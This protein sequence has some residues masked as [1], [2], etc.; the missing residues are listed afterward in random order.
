MTKKPKRL[1]GKPRGG[2]CMASIMTMVELTDRI[3]APLMN[4]IGALNM[5]TEAFADVD[6]AGAGA[7]DSVSLDGIRNSIDAANVGLIELSESAQRM[8]REPIT[9]PVVWDTSKN[10]EVFTNTGMERFQQEI[11]STNYMLQKLGNT[12][13]EITAKASNMEVIPSGMIP[14]LE[15]VSSRMGAIV[16]RVEAMENNTFGFNVEESNAQLES[17]RSQLNQISQL[18]GTMKSAMES[19]NISVANDSFNQIQSILNGMEQSFRDNPI[20]VPIEWDTSSNIEVFTNTGIERFQQEVNSTNAMLDQ[21]GAKQLA[22]ANQASGVDIFPENMVNDLQGISSRMSDINDRIRVIESNPLNLGSDVANRELESLRSQLNQAV[23]QQED[24]NRAVSNM[25]ISAANASYNRL[26]STISSTEQYIRD[27]VDEQGK[28]TTAINGSVS[29]AE[30]LNSTFSNLMQGLGVMTLINKAVNMVTSSVDSAVSRFDTLNNFPKMMQ[31]MGYSAE[32]ANA[33]VNRLSDGIK[34]LPTALND[35]TGYVSQFEVIT[36]NL[37]YATES[38]IALNNAIL[39]GGKSAEVASRA[40]ET[41]LTMFGRGTVDATHWKSL[42]TDMTYALSEVAEAFGYTSIVAGGDFYTAL[43]DGEITMA[44]FNN[45]LIELSNATGGF[46]EVAQTATGGI[47]TAFDN[48]GNAVNRG[49]V[50]ILEAGD[51]LLANTQFESVAGLISRVGDAF[52]SVLNR[53]ATGV[54]VF[55]TL[56]MPIATLATQIADVFA[57]NWSIIAPIVYGIVAALVVYNATMGIGWLTTLRAAAAIVWKTVCDWAETAALIAMTVA[58]DG[59][60]AALAACPITWI[61]IVII[62]LVAILYAVIAVI[63]KATG[64]TISAT[65]IICGAISVAVTFIGNLFVTLGNF[66]IDAFD[67]L[68]N[69]IAS[70]AN[71]LANVFVDPLGAIARLFFS[72]IDNCLNLLQ[73]LAGAIDTLFGKNLAAS[74]SGWRDSLGSWVEDTFGKGVEVMAKVNS[75]DLHLDRFVYTDAW[76]AG[77]SFGQGIEDTVSNLFNP[78]DAVSEIEDALNGISLDDYLVDIPYGD[79]LSAGTSEEDY[80]NS[81][82][83]NTADIAN[84]VSDSSDAE[85]KYLKEIAEKLALNNSTPIVVNVDMSNMQNNMGSSDTDLDGL[86]NGITGAVEEAILISAEGAHV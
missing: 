2:N 46:A 49:V 64:S 17:Y 32:E 81:I 18:Q 60:N 80:L 20:T 7:L 55:G 14:D 10:V 11:D 50:S 47:A 36:D 78:G 33:S 16:S 68:W 34:G 22:I 86:L 70:F 8:A 77:Y 43:Q 65:G 37:N 39:A 21:L 53:I 45:K 67:L 59:L 23:Q 4:I 35:M 30:N 61:I 9:V 19:T 29:S 57:Q 6:A 69:F 73:V 31:M 56:L 58:Q 72:L 52:E 25:D 66:I 74:V 41:Y 28:F 54:T 27:N 82:D 24:L 5:T 15:S 84:A 26:N 71:F 48:M 13:A 83:T 75:Q 44:E 85:L 76:D 38:T 62:A 12:Q 40:T 51:A 63:N 42:T 1:N 79:N 3:S